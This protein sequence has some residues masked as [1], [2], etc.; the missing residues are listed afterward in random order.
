MKNI[1]CNTTLFAALFTALFA[2]TLASFATAD[3]RFASVEVTAEKVNGNVY[4][5]KGAGGNIGASIGEDGTLIIDDQFG[6]LAA[7]IVGA[8]EGIGGDR[9]RLVLNTHWHGDHTGSNPQFGTTA[10]I[11][12]HHNVRVR[13]AAE[14]GY[15]RSGLPLITYGENLSVHFNDEEI[16]VLHLPK[17]HTD[18]DSIVWFKTSNVVHMG[19]HFFNQ[20]YPYVDLG[21]GGDVDGFIA[22]VS[23]ALALITPDTYVIPGH[24]PLASRSDLQKTLDVIVASTAG[25]RERLAAGEDHAAIAAWLQETYPGWGSGFINEQRWIQI[26]AA[27]TT[28]GA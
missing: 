23:Q 19:D 1:K 11:V 21:S 5:L 24:G 3:D 9:P 2:G 28:P 15:P 8:L 25:V 26:I 22:N 4:M 20:R 13:L 27:D 10:T 12:S 6:P 7:K 17:G 14:D 18:G 16:E